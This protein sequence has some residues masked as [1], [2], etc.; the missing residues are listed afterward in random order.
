MGINVLEITT[1]I[2]VQ[3]LG[4]VLKATMVSFIRQ[5]LLFIPI[6]CLLSLVFHKG[7]YGVLYAGP[8]ADI[9]CFLICIFIFG[10]EY[11]KL[12]EVEETKVKEYASSKKH[13]SY[14]G[15][16]IV[17]TISR[18][19]G[20]GG[21]YV[22]QLLAEQLGV[23]FYDK[24]L[25][26]LSAKESGLSKE[27]IEKIDEKNSSMK[28]ESNNDDRLFIAET[29]VIQDLAK[30]ESCVIVGRCAD[31]ILKDHKDVLKIFLYSDDHSKEER[32]TKYYD[33]PKNKASKYIKDTNKKRAKH[34]KYYTGRDWN[35]RSNY[36]LLI[37]VDTFGVEKTA[38][39]LLDYIKNRGE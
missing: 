35:E 12:T 20:S 30:K 19:Y 26:S 25:I 31:Y 10:S 9:I 13:S 7:I 5:I 11:K 6:A 37:N 17:V 36:D 18:E 28:T 3:S 27:Y 29:K 16:H 23:P 39:Q 22:G 15:K 33:I 34:Y 24:E 4:N 21:R 8:I 38:N 14:K 1:S 2:V 32:A